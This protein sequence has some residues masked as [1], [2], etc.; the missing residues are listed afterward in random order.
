MNIPRR[1]FNA[2]TV[3]R[4]RCRKGGSVRVGTR[5]ASQSEVDATK[6]E[7]EEREKTF[8]FKPM[9]EIGQQFPTRA[10]PEGKWSF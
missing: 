10:V 8:S 2:A 1:L 6:K 5:R 4:K 7:K 9:R 3:E